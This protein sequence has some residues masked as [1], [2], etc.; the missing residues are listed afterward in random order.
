MAITPPP[1]PP[2][3]MAGINAYIAVGVYGGCPATTSYVG[4]GNLTG[5]IGGLGISTKMADIT[6]HGPA[7][8][9]YSYEFPTVSTFGPVTFEVSYHDQDAV[10][11]TQPGGLMQLVAS[12]TLRDF[13]VVWPDGGLWYFSAFISKME[14]KA[15]LAGVCMAAMTLSSFGPPQLA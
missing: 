14:V 5:D 2:T 15:G 11:G 3:A 6:P 13:V 7:S 9:A 4:I 12:Q 10:V 1:L 8:P